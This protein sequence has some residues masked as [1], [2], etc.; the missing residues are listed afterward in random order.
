MTLSDHNY[1]TYVIEESPRRVERPRNGGCLV[2]R[3]DSNIFSWVMGDV[4]FPSSC[5]EEVVEALV[6]QVQGVRDIVLSRQAA[7]CSTP[8]F[9]WSDD[10]T[11]IRRRFQATRRLLTRAR[12]RHA[13]E[14]QLN[15]LTSNFKAVRKELRNAI[16]ASKKWCWE[17]VERD[18][19][20]RAFKTVMGKLKGRVLS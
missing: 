10:I 4:V 11:A 12:G 13:A 5:L 19:F 3:L 8:V 15:D 9:W 2:K 17:D 6:E 7:A 20:G 14:D 18:S 1:I 16:C